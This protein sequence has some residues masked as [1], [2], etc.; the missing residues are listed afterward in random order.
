MAASK[1]TGNL[2]VVYAI[3]I[4][5]YYLLFLLTGKICKL[6]GCM[7]E[8]C[9][10]IKYSPTKQSFS[11]GSRTPTTEVRWLF[12]WQHQSWASS[13]QFSDGN[14]KT[15][16]NCLEKEKELLVLE[17]RSPNI[18]TNVFQ[19]HVTKNVDW[20]STVKY[21]LKERYFGVT[22]N[23]AQTYF[24][25]LRKSICT[26]N[27]GNRTADPHIRQQTLWHPFL[28]SLSS[29]FKCLLAN[30][31]CKSFEWNSNWSLIWTSLPL[32]IESPLHVLGITLKAAV[33]L[34]KWLLK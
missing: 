4:L 8:L 20:L 1:I 34:Q 24:L 3:H 9:S 29:S 12:P 15:L 31:S 28:N 11:P 16:L 6:P 26:Y 14:S 27:S 17:R 2:H 5:G 18:N 7:V 10:L 23:M 21:L 30:F 33:E 22:T 13:S 19:V 32:Q 25:V